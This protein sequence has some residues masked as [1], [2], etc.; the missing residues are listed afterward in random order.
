[1]LLHSNILYFIS[2][3]IH[4]KLGWVLQRLKFNFK[5]FY[6]KKFKR[7]WLFCDFL[8]ILFIFLH[9]PV[10][11]NL[12]ISQFESKYDQQ[13]KKDFE[14]IMNVDGFQEIKHLQRNSEDS[15]AISDKLNREVG[16]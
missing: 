5:K 9:N 13:Q 7:K 3:D 6:F 16:S 12:M 4:I 8:H 11:A 1:M 14:K 15:T 2:L 10:S